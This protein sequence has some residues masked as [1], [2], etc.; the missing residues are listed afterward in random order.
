MD[1]NFTSNLE[2][3]V[4]CVG[5]LPNPVEMENSDFFSNLCVGRQC[6]LNFSCSCR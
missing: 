3:S 2:S 5:A 4:I 1:A 6:A